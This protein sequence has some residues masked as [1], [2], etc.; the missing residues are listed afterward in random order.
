MRNQA[1]TV[2]QV[3]NMMKAT[4]KSVAAAC[5]ELGIK[6]WS[7]YA[8]RRSLGL[9]TDSRKGKKGKKRKLYSVAPLIEAAK[10]VT[11]VAGPTPTAKNVT[12][13]VF[14]GTPGSV[15]EMI[16]HSLQNLGV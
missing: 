10:K 14:H 3:E 5:E 12:A 2:A 8:A 4:N 1:E 15:G 7:Y 11:P 9:N 16:R 13:F 6:I